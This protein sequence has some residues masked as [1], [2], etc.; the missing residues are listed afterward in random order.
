MATSFRASIPAMS[1]SDGLTPENP[2]LELGYNL[3]C[4]TASDMSLAITQPK[5]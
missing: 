5:L 4:V 2:P 1:S 3:D